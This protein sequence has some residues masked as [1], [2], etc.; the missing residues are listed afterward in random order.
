[1]TDT[2]EPVAGGLTAALAKVQESLPHVAKDQRAQIGSSHGYDYA[3]LATI[4]PLVLPLLG[5]N[6]LAWVCKPTFDEQQ[7]FV[8]RYQLRHVSGEKE[9][10]DYPLPDPSKSKPQDIGSAV[11]Y[12]R[13]YA[14]CSVVGIAPGGEDDDARAAQAE[15]AAATRQ[16]KPQSKTVA[17]EP[18][19]PAPEPP[20]EKA[21]WP[22]AAALELFADIHDK[23]THDKD[24]H[25]VTPEDVATWPEWKWRLAEKDREGLEAASWK[26]L[27]AGSGLRGVELLDHAK[28]LAPKVGMAEPDRLDEVHGEL[29][30]ELRRD[31]LAGQVGSF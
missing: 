21:Y 29:I 19:K 18:A 20:A 6:G 30:V 14:L 4:S 26:E 22:P 31:I 8:L 25:E 27:L 23:D 16:R 5:R 17:G 9:E 24:T 10:G 7:N 1:M 15:P 28:K 2:L 12:A 13:R 11:T 3:D